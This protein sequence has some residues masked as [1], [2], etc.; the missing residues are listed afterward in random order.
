MWGL[1]P[2]PADVDS[3]LSRVTDSASHPSLWSR[4]QWHRQGI[5]IIEVTGSWGWHP[6]IVAT[7]QTTPDVPWCPGSV[8]TA[9]ESVHSSCS[10]CAQSWLTPATRYSFLCHQPRVPASG[11]WRLS[12]SDCNDV[13]V[14]HLYTDTCSSGQYCLC[15]IMT[16]FGKVFSVIW[17]R[18]CSAKDWL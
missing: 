5:I 14:D 16:A 12:I 4:S 2:V 3:Y 6:L 13:H 1:S 11:D 17:T 7:D 18:N 9:H 15:T 8:Y 10:H